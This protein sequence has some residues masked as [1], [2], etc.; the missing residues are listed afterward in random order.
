MA[1]WSGATPSDKCR[2]VQ[3]L[4]WTEGPEQ[5]PGS[6]LADCKACR[7]EA[8]RAGDMLAALS[9]MRALVATPPLELEPLLIA[10]ATRTR[11]NRARDMVAHPKF[12]R[13]AAV[14]AA[15]A[16][17][18]ATAAFG[19]IVARRSGARPEVA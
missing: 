2:D 5:A 3:R 15:A 14:G 1:G 17:A 7:D 4:M 19:L 12:W 8:R 6:H 11:L 13:G 9:G 18:A 10:E 16:A